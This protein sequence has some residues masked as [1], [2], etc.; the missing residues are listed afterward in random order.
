MNWDS[1]LSS[2]KQICHLDSGMFSLTKS[3]VFWLSIP[4]MFWSL[5]MVA[6]AIW[7]FNLIWDLSEEA[8]GGFWWSSR[9]LL[10]CWWLTWLCLE[11]HL[12]TTTNILT[13][14]SVSAAERK[15]SS[16]TKRNSSHVR[17]TSRSWG[18][19]SQ[20]KDTRHTHKRSRLSR[21]THSHRVLRSFAAS[22]AWWITCHDTCH[23]LQRPCTL[24]RTCSSRLFHGHGPT[25]KNTHSRQR[26]E[27]R[28]PT[29]PYLPST[30]RT[31]NSQLWTT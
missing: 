25:H 3:Q 10:C 6:T 23:T 22:W 31:K 18:T 7:L 9:C 11:R 2:P 26:K 5:Q 4:D 13:L 20:R 29:S 8:A 19:R 27:W 30:T 12:K 16:W 17:K 15:T 28:P 1:L 14:S 21:T 24:S